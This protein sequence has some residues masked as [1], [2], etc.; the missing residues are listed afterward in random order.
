M[1]LVSTSAILA[2][3]QT[4]PSPLHQVLDDSRCVEAYNGCVVWL[5]WC[6]AVLLCSILPAGCSTSGHNLRQHIF[7]LTLRVR[8]PE[9][10]KSESLQGSQNYRRHCLCTITLEHKIISGFPE[11]PIPR[12]VRYILKFVG[13]SIFLL[14]SESN[15]ER[16]IERVS[17]DE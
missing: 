15:V 4:S 9:T 16:P 6:F 2:S 12:F 1:Y 7:Q 8:F 5:C 11:L 14:F 17:G 3:E 10:A 13:V